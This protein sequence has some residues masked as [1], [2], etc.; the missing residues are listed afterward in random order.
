[1]FQPPCCVTQVDPEEP[2]K[3]CKL[4]HF[5][6]PLQIRF[7]FFE[8]QKEVCVCIDLVNLLIICQKLNEAVYERKGK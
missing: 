8:R 1:M 5:Y 6:Q 2:V 4:V 7:L 3:G